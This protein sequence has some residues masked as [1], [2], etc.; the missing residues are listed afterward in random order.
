MITS[1]LILKNFSLAGGLLSVNPTFRVGFLKPAR[2]YSVIFLVYNLEM[3]PSHAL[4]LHR[5]AIRNVV[6]SHRVLNARVFGSVLR[7]DDT[8]ESDLD[9]LVDTTP[10][11]SLLDIAKIQNRLQKLLGISVDVLTPK[12]LPDCF[13]A[14]VLA[15]AVLV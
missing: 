2:S 6:K 15:E 13:R 12:A 1:D 7:G 8:D 3:K 4:N 11:T 14:K 10:E 9:L 5:E